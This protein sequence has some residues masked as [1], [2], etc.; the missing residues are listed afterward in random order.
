M[1]LG[2]TISAVKLLV[3]IG[4]GGS[5]EVFS[6]PAGIKT[7]GLQM[8]LS[9]GTSTVPDKDNPEVNPAWDLTIGKALSQT[10]TG[11]G[12]LEAED[13]ATWNNWWLS[14]AAK[15]CQIKLDQ[16]NF[17]T[18]SGSYY[19]TDF[20]LTGSGPGDNVNFDAT[21]KNAGPVTFA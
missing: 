13:F 3:K 2:T 8:S 21:M 10:I 12:V 11:S 20:K 1:A 19:L 18:Y 17:G 4:D 7:K 9:T 14:G 15:N 6:A 5:P 16:V